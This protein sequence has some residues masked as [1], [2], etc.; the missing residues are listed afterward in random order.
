MPPKRTPVKNS[1]DSVRNHDMLE[2]LIHSRGLAQRNVSRIKSIL[3]QAEEEGAELT[4]AQL[5]V[6]QRSVEGS[7][8]EFTK[9]YNEILA[10]SSPAEREENDDEYFNFVDLHEEVS[11]MLESWLDKLSPTLLPQP[12][13][14]PQP[15]LTNSQPPLVIQPSLPR[16]I[17]T[18]D[19]RFEQWEKFKVMFQDVVDR[20]NEPDRIKLYHLEK[21]LVGDAAGLIDAKTITDGNYAR[22]W[23]LLDERYSDQRRMIDRHLAGLLGVK[24]LHSE[25]FTELRSLVETFDGHVDNLKFLGQGF[26]EVAEYMMVFLISRALDDETK[27]LWESTIRKGE[28]PTYEDTIHFLKERVSVLERCQSSAEIGFTKHRH[29][30]RFNLPRHPRINTATSPAQQ[31]QNCDFCARGHRIYECPQFNEMSVSQRISNVREKNLCF[32]CLSRRHRAIDCPSKMSCSK[33]QRK[34]HS[35]LY[36]V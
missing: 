1:P 8:T 25:S 11:M 31:E 23:Q 19:G 21:A 20:T 36:D 17:P 30:S 7:K 4:P 9:Q 16:A 18:F 26:A 2:V 32:N 33:C 12:Q 3:Q 35:L 5:K 14:Q 6:Y 34:H 29:V 28:L 10:Q 13:Q 27:K 22:A 15:Q 24:R